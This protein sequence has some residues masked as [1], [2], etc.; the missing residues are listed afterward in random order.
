ML[1]RSL[2]NQRRRVGW[3]EA[4]CCL[5]ESES[6]RSGRS[7]ITTA[8]ISIACC[9]QRRR[10]LLK[11]VPSHMPYLHHVAPILLSL[12]V[13]VIWHAPSADGGSPVTKYKIEWDLDKR[14]GSGN[15]GGPLGSHQKVV[16]NSSQCASSPCEYTIPSLSKGQPYHVRVFAYNQVKRG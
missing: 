10:S 2:M 6:E 13:R 7:L 16:T 11:E 3:H 14:F 4:K 5:W 15:D 1:F 12:L 8:R 9:A